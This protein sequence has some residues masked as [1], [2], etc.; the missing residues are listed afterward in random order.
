MKPAAEVAQDVMAEVLDA[1]RRRDL[2]Q[3][4]AELALPTGPL[5]IH[6]ELAGDAQGDGLA[7]VVGDQ[8]EGQVEAGADP[9]PGP[10]VALADEDRVGV[11]LDLRVRGGELPRGR[12]VGGGASAVEQPGGGQQMRPDADGRDPSAPPGEFLHP[13]HHHGVDEGVDPPLT[14]DL[15]RAG[16]DEGV[17]APPGG[18]PEGEVREDADPG[19]GGDGVQGLGGQD[20]LVS[21]RLMRLRA[22]RARTPPAGR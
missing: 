19:S 16:H 22:G 7:E 1:P 5:Q 10:D 11:D 12:P 3:R 20:D 6:H 18:L 14:V 17:D 13:L 4:N 9:G 21:V 2:L 15:H 8:R